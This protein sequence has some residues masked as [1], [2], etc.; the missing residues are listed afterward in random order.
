V[1]SGVQHL[2]TDDP[3]VD[4]GYGAGALPK[5]G[6]KAR[7]LRLEDIDG[8]TRARREAERFL[9]DLLDDLGGAESVSAGRRAL[10]E[11][12][13]VTKA[14]LDD[15]GARYLLGEP[16]DPAGYATLS[17][18]LKRLV[19]TVGLE[20]RTRDTLDLGSYL[21]ARRAATEAQE[22]SP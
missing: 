12:A 10:A 11:S 22:P 13:A 3:Q 17:N 4:V 19:E 2:L 15:Q 20:R 18:S 21:Q 14:M 5:G 6:N 8:R 16:I 9:N 1:N 7:L